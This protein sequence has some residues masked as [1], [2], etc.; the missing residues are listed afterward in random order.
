MTLL[1]ALPACSRHRGEVSA[2]ADA[3]RG[4]GQGASSQPHAGKILNAILGQEELRGT[5]ESASLVTPKSHAGV[6]R[7]I[8]GL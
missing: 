1:P 2:R 8:L 5:V 4:L 6:R 7:E 3:P